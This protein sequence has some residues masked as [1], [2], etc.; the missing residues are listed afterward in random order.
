MYLIGIPELDMTKALLDTDIP[1]TRLSW[2]K[3][4]GALTPG[5]NPDDIPRALYLGGRIPMA[6][7][8]GAYRLGG[9]CLAVGLLLWQIHNATKRPGMWLSKRVREPWGL[10]D[11]AYREALRRLEGAG[12]VTL[13]RRP[14]RAV[15][16]A[17]VTGA[18][19]QD[20][21]E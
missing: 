20:G 10:S 9:Q 15:R 19:G 12:L 2:N 7:L 4:Q 6:W 8:A 3:K 11:K 5:G 17:I 1:T 14:G 21:R 13:E 16:V 18:G